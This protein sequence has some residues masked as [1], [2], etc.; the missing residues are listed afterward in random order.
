MRELSMEQI[1]I[2]LEI[3]A[4]VLNTEAK[5]QGATYGGGA[6]MI[7]LDN[8][9]TIIELVP[10]DGDGENAWPQKT[11]TGK[12]RRNYAATALTKACQALRLCQDS[13]PDDVIKGESGFEGAIYASVYDIKI[14]AAWSGMTSKEDAD[15]ASKAVANMI[16]EC[17]RTQLASSAPHSS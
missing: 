7:V 11:A 3:G 4:N 1:A 15:I 14:I 5:N 2:I 8:G 9:Y 16:D 12:D 6:V 17:A 10:L 13:T